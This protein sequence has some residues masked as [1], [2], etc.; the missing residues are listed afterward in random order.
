MALLAYLQRNKR[1]VLLTTWLVLL[2]TGCKNI[3][4]DK[5]AFASSANLRTVVIGS[6]SSSLSVGWAS[7]QV[8]EGGSIPPLT[9]YFM[10]P[11]NYAVSGCDMEILFQGHVDTPGPVTIDL[12]ALTDTATRRGFCLLKIEAEER[13]ADQRRILLTGGFFIEVYERGYLPIPPRQDIAF[14]YKIARTTA[15]RTIM[16][17]C[18]D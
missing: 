18:R 14:C 16:E 7:C 11:G 17:K 8:E 5:S 15:G 2:L 6:C 3:P 9:M 10:N 13:W 12:S 4:V 1:V